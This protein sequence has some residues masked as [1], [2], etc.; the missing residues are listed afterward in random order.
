MVKM[1][2]SMLVFHVPGDTESAGGS[3]E[4]ADGFVWFQGWN[5]DLFNTCTVNEYASN[6]VPFIRDVRL[7]LNL[8]ALPFSTLSVVE[9]CC[10]ETMAHLALQKF[11]LGF[12]F[13]PF[14]RSHW[15]AR[16]A[17]DK[18]FYWSRDYDD[19]SFEHAGRAEKE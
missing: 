13:K 11:T 7:D 12:F 16:N 19:S 18:R 3:Y 5:N 8:P 15:G 17:R 4:I 10:L 6:L 2:G 1:H 9:F 14:V